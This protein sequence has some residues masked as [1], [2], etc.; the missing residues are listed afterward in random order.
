MGWFRLENDVI[1]FHSLSVEGQITLIAVVSAI[2]S[3]IAAAA[4]WIQVYR[5]SQSNEVSAFLHLMDQYAKPEM[6]TA[7]RG[8]S[9]LWRVSQLKDQSIVTHYSSL[10]ENSS[11]H[12]RGLSR[13]VS[14]YFVDC[15]RLYELGLISRKLFYAACYHPGINVF[16]EIC[17]PLNKHKNG[18]HNSVRAMKVLKVLVQQHGDGLY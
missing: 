15:V 5:L 4:A 16:Y 18:G 17:V 2:A 12:I 11:E 9:K 10:D 13:T 1:G 3:A 14:S 7:V 8:L 6:Q